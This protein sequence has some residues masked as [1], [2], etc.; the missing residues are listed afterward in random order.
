MSRRRDG[1]YS[2]KSVLKALSEGNVEKALKIVASLRENCDNA[3]DEGLIFLA[4]GLI[5]SYKVARGKSKYA[6]S[7]AF[8]SDDY[9]QLVHMLR[10]LEKVLKVAGLEFDSSTVHNL[11]LLLNNKRSVKLMEKAFSF[12]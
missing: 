1:K 10:R 12:K 5:N 9:Q 7:V 11:T 2:I 4:E 3:Q 8:T 6:S